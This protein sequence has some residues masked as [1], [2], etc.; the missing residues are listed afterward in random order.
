MNKS[1]AIRRKCLECNG[2]PLEVSLCTVVLCELWPYRFGYSM[3]DK[4]FMRRMVTAKKNHPEKFKEVV[5][6]VRETL[7]EQPITPKNAQIRMFFEEDF[8]I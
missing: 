4:R 3:K 5:K 1:Q 7:S 2:S 8:E 6:L